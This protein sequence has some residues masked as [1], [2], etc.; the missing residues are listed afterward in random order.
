MFGPVNN[1]N[2]PFFI[3]GNDISRMEP[4]INKSIFTSLI[5]IILISDPIAA[6]EQ[7]AHFLIIPCCFPITADD[8]HL[9]AWY[10]RAML[11]AEVQFLFIIQLLLIAVKMR[12][13]SERRCFSCPVRMKEGNV[14]FFLKCFDKSSWRC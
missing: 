10:K 9:Q 3:N 11:R 2:I 12:G 13:S 4:A 6:E 1:T 14:I 8:F 7:F 5:M